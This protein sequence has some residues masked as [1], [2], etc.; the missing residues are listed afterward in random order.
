MSNTTFNMIVWGT[1]AAIVIISAYL[2]S[3]GVL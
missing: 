2:R 1:V 3:L